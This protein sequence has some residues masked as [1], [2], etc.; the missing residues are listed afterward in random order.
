MR[1]QFILPFLF[2]LTALFGQQ[3]CFDASDKYRKQY[4]D[5]DGIAF[6][7]LMIYMKKSYDMVLG[8]QIP[9]D[10]FTNIKDQTLSLKKY[11]GKVVVINFWS[12]YCPP[13]INE[14]PSFHALQEKYG[15]KLRVLAFTLDQKTDLLEFFKKHAFNAEI[16]PDAR[17][18]VGKYALGSGYPFT[19]LVDPA[20]KIIHYISGGKTA[21]ENQMDV[22]N[23][24]VP[25]IDKALKK[26]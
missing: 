2:C 6:D 25:L 17:S 14:I 20:G 21:P 11:K 22:F 24:L 10:P 4:L 8:C 16:M 9:N 3:T 1:T 15:K 23:E 19:L 5:R 7:S 12:I 13:C 18:F 26:R